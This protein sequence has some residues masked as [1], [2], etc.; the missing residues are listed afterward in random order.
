MEWPLRQVLWAA[1]LAALLPITVANLDEALPRFI[2]HRQRYRD[3]RRVHQREA[4]HLL[5]CTG[6]PN[7]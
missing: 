6:P 4:L 5:F 3:R 1:L 7:A 2:A